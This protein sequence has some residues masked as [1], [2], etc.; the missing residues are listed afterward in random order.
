MRVKG[1]AGKGTGGESGGERQRHSSHAT[2][3]VGGTGRRRRRHHHPAAAGLVCGTKPSRRE[4][5]S[6]NRVQPIAFAVSG[7]SY[8]VLAFDLTRPRPAS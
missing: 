1:A 5:S 7:S 6:L 2:D 4:G 3:S 8:P